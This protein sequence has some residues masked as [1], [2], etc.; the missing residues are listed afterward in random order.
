MKIE[1]QL[2]K[3]TAV[4]CAGLVKA[5]GKLFQKHL[6]LEERLRSKCDFDEKGLEEPLAN[7]VV[8]C[9]EWKVVS[10]WKWNGRSHINIFEIASY[11]QALKDAAR[12]GGGR[13]SFLLDSSVALFS[14]SKGRSSSKALAPL[15]RK[16]MAIAIAF[17]VFASNHFCPTRLNVSDDPTRSCQL[18][19]AVP[20]DPI[21]HA[22]DFDGLYKLAELP[23]LRRWTSN[24][25]ILV[26]GLSGQGHFS[27]PGLTR[28]DWR[29]RQRGLPIS[30]HQ[31]VLDFDSTLGFPGEGPFP[32]GFGGFWIFLVVSSSA[33][34]RTW[35]LVGS[36]SCHGMQP[37]HAEDKAR[38]ERRQHCI[39]EYGRPVQT[40]T[41]LNRDRLL[42]NFADWLKTKGNCLAT[43]LEGA[44]KDP[45]KLNRLLSE[46][47][48]AL[49][50]AGRPY[51][52]YS[53]TINAVGS[54]MPSIRRLLSGAWDMAFA[55][56]REEPFEHHVACPFQVLLALLTVCMCWGWIEIAGILAL[57]WG[58]ICRI[59]EVL[60]AHRKDLILPSDVMNT[61]ASVLLKVQEPK[62]R[63]RAARHQVAKIEY[64]DLV[65][66]IRCAFERLRPETKLWR[67]SPQ[68]LRNRFKQLLAALLLPVNSK[69][70]RRTLD[71]GSMR[72][73]GATHLQMLLEDAELTRRRGRWLSARTMEIYL[74]ESAATLFF[75]QQPP[76]T[77]IRIMQAANAF[78]GMLEKV[79]FFTRNFIPPSTWFFL[80]AAKSESKQMGQNGRQRDPWEDEA[81]MEHPAKQ[82]ATERCK[83]ETQKKGSRAPENRCDSNHFV[84]S[85]SQV[86]P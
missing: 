53:E 29:C 86:S 55:W 7:E 31:T 4:Y 59:G 82:G 30:L 8:R 79:Q 66:L 73:G 15:L 6:Q 72:A 45:E 33:P 64:E 22:L 74:Q 36:V 41:K 56:L 3:G 11:L 27:L 24:W 44:Y 85:P 32:F 26:L 80:V 20:H 23:K 12:E 65:E 81:P 77:K 21:Y 49:F 62:T 38:V 46:Y 35:T 48:R 76:E 2:T 69:P 19:E 63:F 54:S 17:G 78:T 52:H 70:D 13:F 40:V 51:S 61:A 75:P 28:Q 60:A 1:G 5:L 42:K 58:G 25:V 34:G 83:P 57:S 67:S 37:R 50:D 47:G 68:L 84:T 39:L 18:R 71:L 10:S 9:E 14:T 43:L 16:I